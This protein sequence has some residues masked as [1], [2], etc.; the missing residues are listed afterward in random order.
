VCSDDD[1]DDDD[2]DNDGE[3]IRVELNM[4]GGVGDR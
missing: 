1:D 4:I 3:A 2:G